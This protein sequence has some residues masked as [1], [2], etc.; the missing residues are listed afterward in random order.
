MKILPLLFFTFLLLATKPLSSQSYF[1]IKG[2]YTNAW[3]DYGATALPE[4]AQTDVNGFNLSLMYHHSVSKHVRIGM[5]PGYIQRGAACVPGWQPT[6]VGDT[7]VKL[8]YVELPVFASYYINLGKSKF[9]LYG[10]LGYGVSYALSGNQELIDLSGTNPPIAS[11]I[12]LSSRESRLKRLDHGAHS[13]LGLSYAISEK[14][15]IILASDFYY[16]FQNY[17]KINVAKNRSLNVN[18]G[19]VIKL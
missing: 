19:Y 5:E 14:S 8:N 3:P 16:G 11:K 15:Q 18:V 9:G 12:D 4:N 7:K 2:G 13:G 6:F 10:K 1:G 17:D